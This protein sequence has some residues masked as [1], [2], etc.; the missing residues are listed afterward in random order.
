[1]D[2]RGTPRWSDPE[3][4]LEIQRTIHSFDPCIA[5]AIHMFDNEQEEIVSVRE[6]VLQDSLKDLERQFGDTFVRV[7]RNA[8][9]DPE[10]LARLS[11][12]ENGQWQLSFHGINDTVDVSRRQLAKVRALLKS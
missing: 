8:L 3:Q 1:M 11:N 5:C 12:N 4:P 9:V 10:R 2:P 7:H 6:L